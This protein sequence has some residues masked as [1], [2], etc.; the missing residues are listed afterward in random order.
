MISTMRP[1]SFEMS[2]I[3]LTASVII[4]PPRFAS[5]EVALGEKDVTG[6]QRD[7][8]FRV[9]LAMHVDGSTQNG[10]HLFV[11]VHMPSIRLI[12]PV[13]A[14]A[15]TLHSGNVERAPCALGSELAAADDFP[16]SAP[17]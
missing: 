17:D 7:D 10:E 12:R 11:I 2:F 14:H 9:R 6:L 4:L 3:A 13:K 15:G 5:R 16:W 8:L 1:D